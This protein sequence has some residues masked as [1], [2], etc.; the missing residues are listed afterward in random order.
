[1]SL[2][3]CRCYSL[4]QEAIAYSVTWRVLLIDAVSGAEKGTS[5]SPGQRRR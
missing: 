3:S 2:S 5:R 4:F 1:L